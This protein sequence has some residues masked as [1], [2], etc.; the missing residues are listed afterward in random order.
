MYIVVY[1]PAFPP[2]VTSYCT[3]NSCLLSSLLELCVDVRNVFRGDSTASSHQPHVELVDPYLHKAFPVDLLAQILAKG[4]GGFGLCQCPVRIDL[5]QSVR[6]RTQQDAIGSVS[7]QCSDD[8][9]IR[10]DL[11]EGLGDCLWFRAVEENPKHYNT[12]KFTKE[13]VVGFG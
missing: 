1:C 4:L 2:F 3:M 13:R 7:L 11:L 10:M 12:M 6:I 5:C 9:W 8:L